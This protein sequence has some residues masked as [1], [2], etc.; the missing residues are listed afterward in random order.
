MNK[1]GLFVVAL[2]LGGPWLAASQPPITES[3]GI[4]H[5]PEQKALAAYARGMKLKRQDM[6]TALLEWLAVAGSQRS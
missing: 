6:D 2:W 4:Y 5:T 3:M 1:H